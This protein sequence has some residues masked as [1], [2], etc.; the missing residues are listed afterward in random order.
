MG[1]SES[2]K[3][4]KRGTFVIPASLRR[5]FGLDEGSEVIAEDSPQGI[6]IRPAVTLL[7]EVYSPERRAEFLLSNAVDGKDYL[8]AR[9]VVTEMGLDPDRVPRDRP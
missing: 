3:I 8:A 2:G 5:E 9:E 4:G 1:I 6:L 7:V